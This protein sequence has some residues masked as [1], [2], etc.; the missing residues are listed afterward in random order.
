MNFIKEEVAQSWLN[1]K[2]GC[3]IGGYC[4]KCG[5]IK[6]PQRTSCA[7]CLSDN[8]KAIDFP[9]SGKVYAYTVVRK[10]KLAPGAINTPY[11]TG[12]IDF[13]NGIRIPGLIKISEK[14]IYVGQ[15]VETTIHFDE[16]DNLY[17]YTFKEKNNEK[18]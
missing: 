18:N 16:V 10:A 2:Q 11:I 17:S 4:R 14:R 13:S 1:L 8:I 5:I 6:F 9:K 15:E 12:Y 7:E 3:F